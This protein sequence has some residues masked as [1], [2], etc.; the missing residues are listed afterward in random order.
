[1]RQTSWLLL[2]ASLAAPVGCGGD[3]LERA[4]IL[5]VVTVQGSP[6]AGA[7][8][9][10]TPGNGTP[11]EGALGVADAEGKFEVIS[12]RRGD[13]GIPPGEYTVRVSRF[14]EPDGTPV[15]PEGTQA[16]HPFARET[17]PAPF[18]GSDSPLK[19]TISP[20][21]GE[22]KVDLPVKLYEPKAK[23]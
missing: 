15:P 16:D 21:G 14:A 1:M 7:T 3:G 19:V 20:E 10:F 6:L 23:K 12:S 2:I 11:G 22:V 8:V 13:E 17:V 4:P 5:G 18:S 9:Q